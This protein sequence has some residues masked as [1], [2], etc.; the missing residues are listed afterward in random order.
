MKSI[1]RA[2]RSLFDLAAVTDQRHPLPGARIRGVGRS[3]ITSRQSRSVALQ[4]DKPVSSKG[5]AIQQPARRNTVMRGDVH[6]S[7]PIDATVLGWRYGAGID[8]NGD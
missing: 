3:I 4:E 5:C 6:N 1:S 8:G 2:P 7:K